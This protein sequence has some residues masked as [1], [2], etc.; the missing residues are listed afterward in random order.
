MK[1]IASKAVELL[2][3]SLYEGVIGNIPFDCG[4]P[5]FIELYVS[6]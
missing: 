1:V 6:L 5:S 3:K 4:D 2:L